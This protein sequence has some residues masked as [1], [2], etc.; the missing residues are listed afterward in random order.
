MR[1]L[2]CN[3][4]R[5]N[6]CPYKKRHRGRHTQRDDNVKTEAEIRVMHLQGGN[7]GKHRKPRERHGTDF[8]EPSGSEGIWPCWHLDLRLLPPALQ[9]NKCL[10]FKPP[11]LWSLVMTAPGHS[12]STKVRTG[13]QA[14]SF[15]GTKSHE[16]NKKKSMWRVQTAK[17][18]FRSLPL[19]T[20]SPSTSKSKS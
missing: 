16:L 17:R 11:T 6:W 18:N 20:F 19:I 4:I 8:L 15:M 9:E 2:E 3:L 10:L 12:Y 13:L 14:S 7:A 5:Y 1:S